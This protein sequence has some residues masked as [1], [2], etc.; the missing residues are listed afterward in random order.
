[1]IAAVRT[2]RARL[3]S[4]SSGVVEAA[5]PRRPGRT[6]Q[7]GGGGAE[8]REEKPF[9]WHDQSAGEEFRV[10]PREN[11]RDPDAERGADQAAA[12]A[13][14]E[15]DEGLRPGE[16]EPA[17]ADAPKHRQLTDLLADRGGHPDGDDEG[18][19]E[20]RDDRA[21]PESDAAGPDLT[22]VAGPG[23]LGGL[24]AEGGLD[25]ILVLGH[26]GRNVESLFQHDRH[27]ARL[28]G[29]AGGC[30]DH[31]AIHVNAGFLKRPEFRTIADA[32]DLEIDRG[33]EAFDADRLAQAG[34][35]PTRGQGIQ[36]DL[37]RILGEASFEQVVLFED[38][39]PFGIDAAGLHGEPDPTTVLVAST[40]G[41]RE[42]QRPFHPRR[43]FHHARPGADQVG[44]SGV[45]G[46][47][48][49]VDD[50]G[51]D[52]TDRSGDP[53]FDA[54]LDRAHPGGHR[55]HEGRC[56]RHRDHEQG[57]ADPTPGQDVSRDVP[58]RSH[59]SPP[60]GSRR[61]PVR[62]GGP[63]PGDSASPQRVRASP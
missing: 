8:Q 7:A 15:P 45:E 26:P 9:R 28:P 24:Q 4:A 34:V 6:Q 38:R 49:A 22:V 57:G 29:A 30:L 56:H 58:A 18:A 48:V 5:P 11:R 13:D 41:P 40:I 20:E 10:P 12:A 59:P 53:V 21:G 39:I 37:A 62:P 63:G 17:G 50:A 36:Q 55:R 42:G 2:G 33:S 35:Q 32:H 46:G 16:L 1:M 61:R 54:A 43:G 60:S 27:H 44:D 51:V 31:A 14:R 19:G 25:A 3:A 52:G 23:S 47:S